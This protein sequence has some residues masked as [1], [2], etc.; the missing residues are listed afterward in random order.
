MKILF[1][2]WHSFMNRGI[3]SAFDKLGLEYDIFFYQQT[4]WEKDDGIVEQLEMRLKIGEYAFVFSVNF[5]PLISQVCQREQ[6][7]YVSWVYDAP[8]DIRDISSMHNSC[9]RIFFFD[10]IQAEGYRKQGIIAYHMPLAA[11]IYSFEGRRVVEAR[12]HIYQT[13]ISMVGQLYQTEYNYYSIPLSAYQKGYLEGII[14]SQKLVYGGYFLNEMLDSGLLDSLNRCYDKASG[15]TAFITKA[16][17][18]YMLACEITSRERRMALALLSN[19]YKVQLYSKKS[20]ECLKK[21]EFKG[22]ADYYSQMPKI[23]RESKINLNI[24]LK[25]IQSG[26]PLRVFDILGT[27]GFLISNYQMEMPE[28]FELDKDFVVYESMEDL[29]MKVKYY[30]AHDTERERIARHGYETVEKFHTFTQR[31]QSILEEVIK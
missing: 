29:Y 6:M 26:I 12:N 2:Q 1:Y 22:Y 30:L 14:N 3:E 16:E 31:I 19:Y 18:E 21:V 25:I 10:R 8:I 15:G 27:G 24:S 20:D 13:D 28:M 5:A 17:L 23:F 4:D 7:L 11:D 9:N